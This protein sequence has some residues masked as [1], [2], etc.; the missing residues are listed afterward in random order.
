MIG[1]GTGTPSRTAPEPSVHREVML[2]ASGPVL[3]LHAEQG[4][5]PVVPVDVLDRV[6]LQDRTSARWA[7]PRPVGLRCSPSMISPS[8]VV[9]SPFGCHC[10]ASKLSGPR[11]SAV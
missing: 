9:T 10:S 5:L 2:R 1:A 8:I 6:G 3:A 4:D 11:T 7:M